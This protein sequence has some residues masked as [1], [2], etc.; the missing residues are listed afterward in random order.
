MAHQTHLT[1]TDIFKLN[2]IDQML[3]E[4]AKLLGLMQGHL[5]RQDAGV[6]APPISGIGD[7]AL[8]IRRSHQDP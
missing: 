2:K 3:M 6:V 4:M 1:T 7:L 8:A 5:S